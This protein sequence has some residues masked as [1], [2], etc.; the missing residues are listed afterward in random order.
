MG[1]APGPGPRRREQCGAGARRRGERRGSVRGSTRPG[2]DATA[3]PGP[4]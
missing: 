1:H 4:C 2:S 3:P